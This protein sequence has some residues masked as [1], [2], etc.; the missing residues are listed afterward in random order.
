MNEPLIARTS[1]RDGVA[2][3]RFFEPSAKAP[4]GTASGRSRRGAYFRLA[5]AASLLGLAAALLGGL[6]APGGG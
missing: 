4:L 1:D 2:R 5:P 6:G 3:R